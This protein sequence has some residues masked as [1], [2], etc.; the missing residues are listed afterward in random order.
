MNRTL[1]RPQSQSGRFRRD[2]NLFPLQGIEPQFLGIPMR[3][4]SLHKLLYPE[5]S[6]RRKER[7][8]R[9]GSVGLFLLG[10]GGQRKNVTLLE[11]SKASPTGR[12]GV[13]GVEV[14][15]TD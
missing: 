10:E 9:G 2:K 5:H 14:K 1:G 12:S 6:R 7:G 3:N 13:S 4:L 15:K 11:G 8:T